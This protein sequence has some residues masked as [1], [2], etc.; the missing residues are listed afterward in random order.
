MELVARL[1]LGEEEKEHS[2]LERNGKEK[3]GMCD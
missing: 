1:W 2:L 3:K